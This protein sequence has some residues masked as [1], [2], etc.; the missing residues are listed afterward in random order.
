MDFPFCKKSRKEPEVALCQ[1]KEKDATS[2]VSLGN[3]ALAGCE[4][5]PIRM[6]G[7]PIHSSSFRLRSRRLLSFVRAVSKG[8][9]Q[10]NNRPI[11]QPAQESK[12]VVAD[13]PIHPASTFHR[14]PC[15]RLEV[16]RT[17]SA[18]GFRSK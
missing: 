15:F 8:D 10:K 3:W 7:P 16:S 12:R 17:M 1:G 14:A 13:A 9:E 2:T 11:P 5:P 18:Q 4:N 6:L